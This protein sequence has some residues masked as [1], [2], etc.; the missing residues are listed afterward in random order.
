[1]HNPGRYKIDPGDD[2]LRITEA[3]PEEGTARIAKLREHLR[4]IAPEAR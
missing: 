4:S 1:M 2:S 3:M